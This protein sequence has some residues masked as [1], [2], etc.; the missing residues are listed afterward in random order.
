MR[1]ALAFV[2]LLGAA[3]FAGGCLCI[4]ATLLGLLALE[5]EPAARIMQNLLPY[6]GRVM[7]PLLLLTLGSSVLLLG[8]AVGEP[9]LGVPARIVVLAAMVAIAVV[10]VL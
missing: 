7:G 5:P 3:G 10:T 9:A 2:H 1:H 8:L 4:S 6:M